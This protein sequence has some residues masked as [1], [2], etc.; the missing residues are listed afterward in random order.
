VAPVS[1]TKRSAACQAIE[2]FKKYLRSKPNLETVHACR[3][4]SQ[5]RF[6]GFIGIAGVFQE[7][8]H[9]ALVAQVDVI[10]SK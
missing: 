8:D 6:D 4:L 9:G 7:P 2:P 3:F 5:Q 1:A 10:V